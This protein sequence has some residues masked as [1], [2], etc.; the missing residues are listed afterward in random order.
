MADTPLKDKRE[1][2]VMA[3]IGH[4]RFNATAAA[5]DAGYAFPHVEGSRLLKNASVRA[6][7]DAYLD[8]ESLSEKEVLAELADIAKA[9]WKHFI[10]VK[11]DRKTGEEI[12]VKMDLSNKVKSL[13]LLGKH[14]KTFSDNIELGAGE[15]FIDALRVFGS[16]RGT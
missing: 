6:R 5:K 3:Y 9:E 10:T 16:G 11:T 12:E 4:C 15:S 1:A 13:E 14:Y 2:F 8:A 7:V